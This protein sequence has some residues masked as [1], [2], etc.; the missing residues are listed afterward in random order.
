[1]YVSCEMV[2]LKKY[3]TVHKHN[4]H[5]ILMLL[6]ISYWRNKSILMTISVSCIEIVMEKMNFRCLKKKHL[7][8]L[9]GV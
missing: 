6:L 7:G 8:L 9:F 4:N 2:L 3:S 1:M 5:G